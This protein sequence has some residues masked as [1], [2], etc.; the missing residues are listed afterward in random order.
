MSATAIT[1]A[2]A[3]IAF[4]RFG[5]LS[6]PVFFEA[7]GV[8]STVVCAVGRLIPASVACCGRKLVSISLETGAE[9]NLT[10]P[11]SALTGPESL[12]RAVPSARQKASVSS[13]STRL[14]A[15]HRF[16]YVSLPQPAPFE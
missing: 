8:G 11:A 9:A 2:V 12:I 3:I 16:I 1:A 6:S 14:H 15:G 5:L 7:S 13:V 10:V 4:R